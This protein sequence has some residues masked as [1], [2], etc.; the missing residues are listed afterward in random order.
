MV[1]VKI[2]KRVKGNELTTEETELNKFLIHLQK[3]KG[4]NSIHQIFMRQDSIVIFYNCDNGI[5]EKQPFTPTLNKSKEKL[6][7]QT[8]KSYNTTYDLGDYLYSSSTVMEDSTNDVIFTYDITP[9][10]L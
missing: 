4:Y 3:S 2:F 8:T 9:E 6:Q 10:N 5:D 7:K 1:K